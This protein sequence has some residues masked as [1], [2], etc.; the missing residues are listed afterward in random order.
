MTRSPRFPF[1]IINPK[2]NKTDADSS[3]GLPENPPA[4][5]RPDRD[6]DFLGTL[7]GKTGLIEQAA[8]AFLKQDGQE[9]GIEEF[10]TRLVMVLD[11]LDALRQVIVKTGDPD[12]NRG[13]DFFFEKLS[14][15][16]S[17]WELSAAARIGMTFDPAF[18]RAAGADPLSDLPAGSI[19]EIVRNGWIYKGRL[20]RLA[21]V[22][23]S[24]KK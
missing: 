21:E 4:A 6:K 13:I 7:T 8:T 19:T 15:L 23:V 9:R 14:N 5:P 16:L 18:H 17:S 1:L 12:W 22:V 3:G 24:K 2:E 20:L 11:D 10:F